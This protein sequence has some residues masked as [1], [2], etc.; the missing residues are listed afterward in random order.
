MTLT[1]V[2]MVDVVPYI[3]TEF[4]PVIFAT[5]DFYRAL[6]S[7]VTRHGVV[8]VLM[9]NRIPKR[10]ASGHPHFA[11]PADHPLGIKAL[12]DILFGRAFRCPFHP[13]QDCCI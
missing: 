1:S 4:F 9:K 8:M 7:V 2:A 10:N 11:M 5:E 3:P 12:G 6:V 13:I